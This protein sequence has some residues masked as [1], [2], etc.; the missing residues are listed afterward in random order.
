VFRSLTATRF[1]Q[2]VKVSEKSIR[3]G[4]RSAVLLALALLG[5]GRSEAQLYPFFTYS[6][7]DGLAQSAVRAIAQDSRGYLWFGT[8]GGGVSRFDGREFATL[9]TADGL[10]DNRVNAIVEDAAGRLWFATEQGLAVYDGRLIERWDHAEVA[11]KTILSLFRDRS[12]RLWIGTDGGVLRK[13]G[14]AVVSLRVGEHALSNIVLAIAE[15]AAGELWVGTQRGAWRHTEGGFVRHPGM[16]EE[17]VNTL[18]LDSR[19]ELWMTSEGAGAGRWNIRSFSRLDEQPWLSTNRLLA[20]A[21][22]AAG[23]IWLGTYGQGVVRY[24]EG[25]LR[26]LTTREGLPSN[27]VGELRLDAEGNLW[28][29]TLGGGACRLSDET[30]LHFTTA[31]GLASD[32]V[33]AIEEDAAG[34]LWIGTLEGGVNIY[35]GRRFTHLTTADGLSGDT[36]TS[37]LADR[38]GGIWL[39]T[40]GGGVTY[41]DGRRFQHYRSDAGLAGDRVFSVTEDR[42]GMLWFSTWGN[43]ISRFDGTTFTNF[44][45]R[46][47]LASD[48]VYS[49]YEDRG[50]RLWFST[51]QGISRWEEDG[52]FTSFTISEGHV[53]SRVNAVAE[54]HL[55][56]LWLATKDGL[57]IFDGRSFEVVNRHDGLS[58]ETIYLIIADR[59]GRLWA[60]SERGLD[61][62]EL[63]ASGAVAGIRHFGKAEGF[64]GIETNQNAVLEDRAGHLWFGTRGLTRYNPSEERPQPQPPK[65]HITDLRLFFQPTDWSEVAGGTTG[66][67]GLPVRLVLPHDQNHLQFRFVGISHSLAA[68]VRYQ[69]RLEGLD[70]D[71][72]PETES[73][74]AVYS[75]LPPGSYTFAVRSRTGSGAWSEP[76][77]FRFAVRP[78]FW[79]TWWFLALAAVIAGGAIVGGFKV[80]TARLR[81]EARRLE[82]KVSWRTRELAASEQRYRQLAADLQQAKEVAEI[83]N[84]AKSDF[85][86]HMSHEIRTPL[87][88]VVG[89]TSLLLA[90]ALPAELRDHVET[91]RLSAE[92]LLTLI[93]DILDFS[94]IESGA[95]E[96][97]S[98]PFEVDTCVED[99]LEVMA[100]IAASKG[101]ELVYLPAPGGPLALTGDATRTRQV[102]INLVSNAVKFTDE[103]EVTVEVSA[104]RL[105]SERLEVHF[106]LRDTGIGIPAERLE[107]LFEPFRQLDSSTTRRFGGT[108]LGLAISRRLCDL[109]GGRIWAESVVGQG[110]TFHFTVLGTETDARLEETA[111]ALAGKRLLVVDA[112]PATRCAL[113]DLA[114]AAGMECTAVASAAEALTSLPARPSYDFA[115]VDRGLPDMSAAELA[116]AMRSS[117]AD[118]PPIVLLGGVD[119]VGSSVDGSVAARITKP[120][121][122]RQLYDLLV[123][124]SQGAV[125]APDDALAPRRSTA[126]STPLRILLAEDMAVNQ[127]V[128]LLMLERLGYRADLAADGFEAVEAVSRQSYDV[129]LMDVEMPRMDGLEATR[130]IRRLIP[131][132]VRPRIIGITA[133]AMSGDRERFLDA[134]MDDY[135]SKPIQLDQLR[136]ALRR[137]ALPNAAEL[138][139]ACWH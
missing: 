17:S 77:K 101:L 117:A 105:D 115:L 81:V 72:S 80:K 16:G 43:G 96:L 20:V 36:V 24:A 103:G 13:Q 5:A 139:P 28:F 138:S 125:K 44:S 71:W 108:G 53:P 33:L 127:K 14:E 40:V 29:G 112:H 132:E 42:H 61:R 104:Q 6:V 134:G 79:A 51:H 66:W 8:A 133:H 1:P 109:M 88:G 41:Y 65:T 118:A 128:V 4:L 137:T 38:R 55:G 90:S 95:L 35:D 87:N 32:R 100:P 22:D 136:A 7:E 120:V 31:N 75:S 46:D 129:V 116:V 64:L 119:A 45:Q 63:E 91:I 68:T 114:G 48:T 23:R 52:T 19:G 10:P 47:G 56:R 34:R 78:P 113:S 70:R 12:D 94:K 39:T 123:R 62:I 99:A 11:G 84:R 86:A 25:E 92:T 59:R 67:H 58:S 76:A 27:M 85:L 93:N 49:A 89:M 54:D 83:A 82:E 3:S 97:E 74:Q 130:Q 110:S 21:E 107:T 50:G 124:I 18:F 135:L 37:I 2:P 126:A 106:A 122:R 131:P 69:Y 60:G 98:L 111:T 121:R 102:L 15:D 9:S 73:R 26:Q 57:S 30:F